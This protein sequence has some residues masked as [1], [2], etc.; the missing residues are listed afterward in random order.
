MRLGRRA[1]CMRARPSPPPPGAAALASLCP[2]SARPPRP[3][4]HAHPTPP[5]GS[6]SD[7]LGLG[8]EWGRVARDAG[9]V[10]EGASRGGEAKRSS[11]SGRR[12]RGGVPAFRSRSRSSAS[13]S[14]LPARA[15]APA[16]PAPIPTH[17]RQ[18]GRLTPCTH[19]PGT[20]PAPRPWTAGRQP[21]FVRER[22]ERDGKGK[23]ERVRG[24]RGRR[25]HQP[26]PL[27][28][29]NPPVR[30]PLP[31]PPTHLTM[32][33][34]R[35]P[36]AAS[37]RRGSVAAKASTGNWA[38]GTEKPKYLEGAPGCVFFSFLTLFW[39]RG[40]AGPAS[41]SAR[42]H[43]PRRHCRGAC[44]GLRPGLGGKAGGGRAPWGLCSRALIGDG[45]RER[46]KKLD[47][48][49]TPPL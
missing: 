36:L 35:T 13:S 22:R 8:G 9:Q 21:S 46:T 40:Y 19:S 27:S 24:G 42:A 11:A 28:I 30:R 2:S 26:A 48:R 17:P 16:G 44:Q 45:E 10:R 43:P 5:A 23:V 3:A 7:G 38:P 32:F 39:R 12:R 14:S 31:H 34:L 41:R 4:P 20:R 29:P 33:A 37:T 18:R 49:Q 1:L 47:P 6:T 25:P 15:R